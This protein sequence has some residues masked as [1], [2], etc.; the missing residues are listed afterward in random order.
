MPVPATVPPILDGA[1]LRRNSSLRPYIRD[2]APIPRLEE[3][4][5]HVPS[6][7]AKIYGVGETG[8]RNRS[9]C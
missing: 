9:V 4:D 5:A 8:D 6:G 2:L 7:L 1:R 3:I